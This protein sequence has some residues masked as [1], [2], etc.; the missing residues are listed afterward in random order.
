MGRL[1]LLFQTMF[2]SSMW[3][4]TPEQEL[5]RHDGVFLLLGTQAMQYTSPCSLCLPLAPSGGSYLL[6]SLDLC[7]VYKVE[8]NPFLGMDSL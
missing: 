6:G 3:A 4:G 1:F 7:T 8:G 5:P 2:I